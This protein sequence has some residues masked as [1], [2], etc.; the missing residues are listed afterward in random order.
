MLYMYYMYNLE[1]HTYMYSM[2]IN[3]HSHRW[4]GG[5]L[6]SG[7]IKNLVQLLKKAL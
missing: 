3:S 4:S 5:L 2:I 6:Q 1:G 7:F